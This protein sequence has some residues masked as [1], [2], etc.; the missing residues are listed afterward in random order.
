MDSLQRQAVSYCSLMPAW[1]KHQKNKNPVSDLKTGFLVE[2]EAVAVTSKAAGKLE[3]DAAG[4]AK[5]EDGSID[6]GKEF[7]K[8]LGKI[9]RI[10]N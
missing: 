3:A 7:S 1:Q 8:R 4:G 5:N 2:S 10:R 9:V 6:Y